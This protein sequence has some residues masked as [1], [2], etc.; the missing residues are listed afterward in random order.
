MEVS[1]TEVFVTRVLCSMVLL[2]AVGRAQD[3]A[4]SP[5]MQTASNT[6]AANAISESH[7]GIS[8]R[9]ESNSRIP[10]SVPTLPPGKTTLLG[11][12]IQNVDSMRDRL[13]LRIF[14]GGRTAILFDERTQVFRDG[15]RASLDDLKIG[16][17]AY[18]DT[19]LDGTHIFARN[20]RLGVQSGA[21]QSNGQ[22]VAFEPATGELTVR[23]NLAPKAVEML[24]AR[25]AVILS[26]DQAALPA[27][28]RPGTL[29]N[30]EF[31]PGSA[32]KPVV[33]QISILAAPGAGFS[34]SGRV[35][36]L[37]LLNGLLVLT[38]P[39]DKKSYEVSLD[40][41]A[42]RLTRDL[43]EGA[44]VTVETTFDGTHYIAHGITVIPAPPK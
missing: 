40:S 31:S 23:D 14:G 19:T 9:P 44:D 26:G 43:L 35:E 37:D 29:V 24:L 22:I 34:F 39:R 2:M 3:K 30:M 12:L 11:G 7:S 10:S 17:R 8:P 4:L 28:L 32:G 38:D 18:V 42:S 13:T 20:I 16:E 36:H 21:G 5:L 27:A 6:P 41:A 1:V 25:D 33:R 15:T